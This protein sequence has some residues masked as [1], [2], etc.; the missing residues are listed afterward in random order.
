MTVEKVRSV[1][2]DLIDAG[3]FAGRTEDVRAL[4]AAL[5]AAEAALTRTAPTAPGDEGW[6]PMSEEPTDR[7]IVARMQIDGGAWWYAMVKAWHYEDGEGSRFGDRGYRLLHYNGETIMSRFYGPFHS[8][9]EPTADLVV[10]AP[11]LLAPEAI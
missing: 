8:W 10:A 3:Y 7:P 1:L 6:R 11:P 2:R 5:A 4:P 9:C